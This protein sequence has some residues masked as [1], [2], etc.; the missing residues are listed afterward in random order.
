MSQSNKT[1]KRGLRTHSSAA[2][3]STI[4]HDEVRGT[5]FWLA[6]WLVSSIYLEGVGSY[7]L[8]DM[9]FIQSR[10]GGNCWRPVEAQA[11]LDPY[12]EGNT[13]SC[14]SSRGMLFL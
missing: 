11:G 7:P 9:Y 13:L 2:R 6:P 1:R 10:E 12:W 3:V 4:L 14:A 5:W 8:S